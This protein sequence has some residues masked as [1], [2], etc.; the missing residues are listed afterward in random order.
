MIGTLSPITLLTQ[1]SQVRLHREAFSGERHD[2]IDMKYGPWIDG[3]SPAAKHT[4]EPVARQHAVSQFKRDCPIPF[5]CNFNSWFDYRPTLGDAGLRNSEWL[6]GDCPTDERRAGI[7]PTTK[8]LFVRRVRVR[9]IRRLPLQLRGPVPNHAPDT[10]QLTKKLGIGDLLSIGLVVRE[11]NADGAEGGRPGTEMSEHR[12]SLARRGNS[13]EVV[14]REASSIEQYGNVPKLL[15]QHLTWQSI[16]TPS[17]EAEPRLF[18]LPIN[19]S[20]RLTF[21]V[22]FLN[23]T[24]SG[25]RGNVRACLLLCREAGRKA[26]EARIENTKPV[27]PSL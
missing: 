7:H 24:L 16:N 2:V 1:R 5:P 9:G 14:T 21:Y 4:A 6:H 22:S 20:C 26:T 17:G 18:H 27:R 8:P 13:I 15:D 11:G 19:P 25:I 3:G 12:A 23:D 10:S